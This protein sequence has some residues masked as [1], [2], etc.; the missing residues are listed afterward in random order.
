M[1]INSGHLQTQVISFL[2][3]N[4]FSQNKQLMTELRLVDKQIMELS[5]DRQQ[6]LSYS[7]LT[8]DVFIWAV[9]AQH[10]ENQS[11][12]RKLHIPL[13]IYLLTEQNATII[14]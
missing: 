7:Q 4:L 13:T 1:C 3:F 9:G 11:A 2:I 12:M 10:T 5:P 6:Y 8:E 14:S